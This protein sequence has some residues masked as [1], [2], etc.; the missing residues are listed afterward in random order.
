[1]KSPTFRSLAK[2]QLEN[3]QLRAN[4]HNATQTIR[5]K[6]TRAIDELDNYDE[7][8]NAGAAIKD[9]AIRHLD[10]YLM[11]LEC[12]LRANGAQ[13]HWASTA[14]EAN[15]IIAQ[16]VKSQSASEVLK[17]KSMI[18]Q[19]IGMNDALAEEGIACWETDLAE[20]IV[21]L[22]HDSP[23]HILVPAVHK[24]RYEVRS[25][26]LNEMK[27]CGRPAPDD[28]GDEPVELAA[29]AHE[30]LR[31]KFLSNK[32]AISG[33]NF[34][35]A[36]TGTLAIV[37]S[38]GNG[39]MCLTLADTLI[40][41]VGIE[42]V[43]PTLDDLEVFLQ[44]LPRSSTGERMNPYTSLWSGVS[45]D[46]GPQDV[47]VVLVD[48]GRI[49][50]LA[51]P[52]GRD[53]LRCIRCSACI[54]ICPVY[55]RVG[56][57]AYGSVYPGPMGCVLTPQLRGFDTALDRSLPFASTLCGA[58]A[59]VCP[60]EIPLPDLLVHLRHRV[61]E[62]KKR[63]RPGLEQLLMAG[64][65]WVMGSGRRFEA[66]GAAASAVMRALRVKKLRRLPG[67]AGNW[68]RSRDL[69]LP[70]QRPARLQWRIIDSEAKPF[71]EGEA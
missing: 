14:K 7:L 6:R 26:F 60:M 44:L 62:E 64:T 46:D 71:R 32:V 30:H 53:I 17:V 45:P 50:A 3:E 37:E 49:R 47:H 61:V 20:L 1:M 55:E 25:I 11:Q 2:K 67:K 12:S 13:V 70:Q 36:E 57:H 5:A 65:G 48:N 69:P 63:G 43:I 8:R 31:E 34:A 27:H 18:T 68:T 59:E 52:K 58:C 22:D 10:Y 35:V 66:A 21:Q 54:N 16:L 40:S 39:R 15:A 29:C 33:A 56:G 38:E 19:E 51:D 42:K 28:L 24:N 9:R 41:V 23:S 4:L